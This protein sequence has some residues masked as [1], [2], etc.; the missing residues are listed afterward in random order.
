MSTRR[1]KLAVVCALLTIGVPASLG[2]ESIYTS[3]KEEDC[4]NP[5]LA[6][7]AAY[8][9]D[10]L[11]VQECAAPKGWRLFVVSSEERSWVDISR[12]SFLWS[13]ERAVVYENS[14]GLFPNVGSAVA[15]WMV[16]GDGRLSS[17]IFR[18]SAQDPNLPVAGGNVRRVSRL[19]VI[20]LRDKEPTSCG[21]AKTNQEAR[22]LAA[23]GR[24]CREKLPQKK[25]R[26]PS[27]SVPGGKSL[28]R[29]A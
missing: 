15:E 19:L 29:P 16:A 17:L 20:D 9:A 24:L 13:T 25:F 22:N 27:P 3:L 7:S 18:I 4:H 2:A 1:T 21:L 6:I 28:R 5:P 12:G 11:T 23:R 8:D 10:D 14:F 26:S